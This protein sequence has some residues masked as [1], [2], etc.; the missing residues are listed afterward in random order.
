MSIKLK[1]TKVTY[2]TNV[3]VPSP[4]G[5]IKP[6]YRSKHVEAEAEVCLDQDPAD[7]LVGLAQWVHEQLGI[8][9]PVA[10]PKP[11]LRDLGDED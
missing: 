5:S 8:T 11:V 10:P 1:I 6:T 3:L 9:R 4:D 7:V 2:R